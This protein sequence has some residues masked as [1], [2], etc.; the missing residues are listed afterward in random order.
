[1]Y[2]HIIVDAGCVLAN[3]LSEDGT[4]RIV[5]IESGPA[6]RSLIIHIPL[7]LAVLALMRGINWNLET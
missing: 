7:G 3:L 4:H 1:M 6:D 2:D 5:L